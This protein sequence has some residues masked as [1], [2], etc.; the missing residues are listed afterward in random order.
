MRVIIFLLLI[1]TL[2]VGA[3]TTFSVDAQ[4]ER[5]GDRR[6]PNPSGTPNEGEQFTFGTEYPITTPRSLPSSVKDAILADSDVKELVG[7][8]D[9]PLG[10]VEGSAIDL[11]HNELTDYIVVGRHGPLL[12]ANVT[13]F[14]LFLN[15]GETYELVLKTVGLQLDISKKFDGGLSR[16]TVAGLTAKTW[17][18]VEYRYR[19]GRYVAAKTKHGKL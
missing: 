3:F 17:S 16:V 4:K 11:D 6:M 5:V 19:N 12:G 9:D 15:K 7:A 1:G 18:E 2:G 8:N 13:T 14:W 10:W